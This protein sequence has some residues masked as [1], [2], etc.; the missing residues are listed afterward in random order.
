MTQ[1]SAEAIAAARA[2]QKKWGIPA[3]ISLS[4]W[5]LESA[6][7]TRTAGA[8]NFFGMKALPGQPCEMVTTHEVYRGN[9]VKVQAAFRKFASCADAFDAHAKLLATAG[10]YAHAR[11][12]LPN[13]VAFAHALTGIYATDPHYGDTLVAVM[14]GSNLTRYDA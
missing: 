4:Q 11:V 8:F 9:R 12:G 6:W 3:S 13:A 1:P 10:V 14:R 2:A 7:G 5:A